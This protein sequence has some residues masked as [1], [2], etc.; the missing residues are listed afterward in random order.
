MPKIYDDKKD[1]IA[2][3]PVATT[4]ASSTGASVFIPE[5]PFQKRFPIALGASLIA[6]VLL[7]AGASALAQRAVG[8]PVN[9]ERPPV[10]ITLVDAPPPASAPTPA[11]EATPAPKAEPTP[12]PVV[13]EVEPPKP[14]VVQPPIELPRITPRRVA[15]REPRR[16][17]KVAPVVKPPVVAVVKPTPVTPKP[18]TERAVTPPPTETAITPPVTAERSAANTVARAGGGFGQNNPDLRPQAPSPATALGAASPTAPSRNRGPLGSGAPSLTAEGP[19]NRVLTAVGDAKGT[20]GTSGEFTTPDAVL[21]RAT[22]APSARLGV[23]GG[24]AR[25]DT[26]G[27][28]PRVLGSGSGAATVVAPTFRAARGPVGLPGGPAGPRNRVLTAIDEKSVAAADFTIPQGGGVRAGTPLARQG[29]AGGTGRPASSDIA[30]RFAGTGT[31]AGTGLAGI[32]SRT[33]SPSTGPVGG[34][35]GP[36]GPRRSALASYGGGEKVGAAGGVANGDPGGTFGG[37]AGGTGRPG[38]GPLTRGGFGGNGSGPVGTALGTKDG[39]SGG[40][41]TVAVAGRLGG[42][43]R[44]VV[45]SGTGAEGPRRRALTGAGALGGGDKIGPVAG[46]GDPSGALGGTSDGVPGGA[47]GGTGR[48]GR[49]ASARGGTG[50]GGGGPVGRALALR[51]AT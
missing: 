11:P 50:G 24:V 8:M 25:P 4:G 30:P 14:V 23:S 49:I 17:I 46:A 7:V 22:G 37:V 19:R 41:G 51:A 12:A 34:G 43:G 10:E 26:G 18:L 35:S 9:A 29:I 1:G 32:A 13:P 6:N 36:I 16:E 38:R 48:G 21:P 3:V 44:G 20:P 42:A 5:D 33:Y 39:S 40:S 28:D 31:G 15:V 47:A 2:V 45:G 27:V